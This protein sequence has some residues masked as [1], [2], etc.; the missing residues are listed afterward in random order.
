MALEETSEPREGR[1]GSGTKKSLALLSE[2][3]FKPFRTETSPNPK[4]EL[5]TSIDK[6]EVHGQTFCYNNF[7]VMI[8]NAFL[9][10]S[11]ERKR[12]ILWMSDFTAWASLTQVKALLQGIKFLAPSATAARSSA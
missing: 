10:S 11:F 2:K 1:S 5:R 6:F 4:S 9:I 3:L 8:S 12:L 7:S